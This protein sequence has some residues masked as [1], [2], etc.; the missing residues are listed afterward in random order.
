MTANGVFSW[1]RPDTLVL[2]QCSANNSGTCQFNSVLDFVFVSGT[3]QNWQAESVIIVEPGD[4][5]DDATTPDHRP[6]SGTFNTATPPDGEAVTR[7]M[8]LAQIERLEAELAALRT[9][10]EQMP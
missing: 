9:L 7:E 2:T 8:L 4:F 10:V 5:P 3:A 6:V 1:V